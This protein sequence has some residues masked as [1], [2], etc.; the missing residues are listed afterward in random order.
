MEFR[1][2]GAKKPAGLVRR[3]AWYLS[4]LDGRLVQATAVRRHGG[5]MMVVVTVMAG[6]LHL[7]ETLRENPLVCQISPANAM[8]SLLL[9]RER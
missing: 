6:A 1:L 9:D 4:D 5:S 8:A 7:F 3:R 2:G